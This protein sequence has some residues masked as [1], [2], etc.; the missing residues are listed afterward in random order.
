[1]YALLGDLDTPHRDITLSQMYPWISVFLQV[2]AI[3]RQIAYPDF[4]KNNS[5]LNQF[6]ETVRGNCH[7]KSSEILFVYF[8]YDNFIYG[9]YISIASD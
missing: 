2:D 8:K 9:N 7:C 1:M 6:Y 4:I 5:K 3:T